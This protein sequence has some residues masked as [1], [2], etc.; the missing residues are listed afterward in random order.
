[1]TRHAKAIIKYASGLMQAVRELNN[2]SYWNTATFT[3][4]LL[5]KMWLCVSEVRLHVL[6]MYPGSSE[7]VISVLYWA[8]GWTVWGSN[9]GGGKQ[10]ILPPPPKCTEWLLG[11]PSLL[12][13]GYWGSV[14][15]LK[16]TGLMLN[17]NFHLV[18]SLG[19]SGAVPLP[20]HIPSWCGQEDHYFFCRSSEV[21]IN[22]F[23]FPLTGCYLSAQQCKCH[24]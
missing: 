8:V 19:V 6:Y 3:L 11:P 21:L 2:T 20:P 10:P 12:L 5:L 17:T 13:N 24:V 9:P 15:G 1:M 7:T 23:A 18:P 14:Q 4:S 22:H 16:L